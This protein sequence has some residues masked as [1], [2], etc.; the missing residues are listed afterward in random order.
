MS[1]NQDNLIKFGDTWLPNEY[2]TEDGYVVTP[3]QRTELEAY[4]NADVL[5]HRVTSPNFKTSITLTLCPMS[6]T[7]KM[8][9]QSII[10][11]AMIVP[12]ERKVAVTYWNDETNT[13]ETGDFY[14]SDVT[15]SVMG[16][17]GGERWYKSVT[18]QLTEY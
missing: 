9:V 1:E 3:N 16:Y 13:Y 10:N 15:Y 2:I 11:S 5:L 14:I 4:R 17:Y 12:T 8:T 6:L 18:Y 7:E